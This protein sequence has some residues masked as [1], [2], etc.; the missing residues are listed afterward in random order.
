MSVPEKATP[1]QKMPMEVLLPR[2]GG[3]SS[4][5]DGATP[6]TYYGRPMIKKPTWKWP[7][8]LYFF[9]GGVAGGVALIGAAADFFGGAKHKTTVRHARYLT[10]ILGVICP[11]PL[12]QDLGRPTRFHHMLRIFKVTSPLNIGTW[13]LMAFGLTSGALAAKQLAEDISPAQ[14]VVIQAT[15]ARRLTPL[16]GFLRVLPSKP[17][18]ALH[19]LLGVCL[20]GYTGVLLAVT[21]VP[22]WAAAGIL[23]GPLFLATSIA[24]GAAAL[25]LASIFS[26]H[27]DEA[28]RSQIE[29][30]ETASAVA[31]LGL[32]AAR[33]ALVPA[34]INKPLRKGLWGKIW[35][36]GALGGVIGP[37]V[38][39]LLMRF[40][41]RRMKR[42]LSATASTLSL[43]GSLAERFSLTE[44]GKLS[45]NDP[46]AYQEL[47]KGAPGESRPT[48]REQASR[49]RNTSPHRERVA[50]SDL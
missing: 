23:L 50:T 27:D 41:G 10:L 31:Q 45:A 17:L 18:S 2:K 3:P 46:I 19:G 30:V 40:S 29:T 39:R 49:A 16:L 21:A 42:A 35:Q 43:L 22:L 6:T 47:T 33:E 11:I 34:K 4:S 1:I 12:I 13:I 38:L 28:A 36:F 32:I 15:P 37:L 44:A 24:S 20:G 7:I 14:E 9:L 5:H 48:P 8:P 25:T 26:R